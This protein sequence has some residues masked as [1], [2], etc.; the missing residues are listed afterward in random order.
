[1]EDSDRVV[2]NHQ[3]RSEDM[4]RML[5]QR[6]DKLE[7]NDNEMRHAIITLESAVRVVTIEQNHAKELLSARLLVIEK[8]MEIG[9]AKIDRLS[10]DILAM[11]GDVDKSPAG[12]TLSGQIRGVTMITDGLIEKVDKLEEQHQSLSMWQ[13][14][15]DTAINILKWVGAGGVVSLIIWIVKGFQ[16]L[17]GP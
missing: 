13:N 7:K 8:T 10:Q 4:D 3:R 11:A 2:G 5:N 1:M 14:R 12:R 17:G 9:N 15:I 6:L 16:S